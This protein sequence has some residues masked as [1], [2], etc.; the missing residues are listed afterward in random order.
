MVS[1]SARARQIAIMHEASDLAD[2][3]PADFRLTRIGDQ[4]NQIIASEDGRRRALV[5]LI[6]YALAWVEELDHEAIG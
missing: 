3:L 1:V 6:A 2:R 5:V 4:V